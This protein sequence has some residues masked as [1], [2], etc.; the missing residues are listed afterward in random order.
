MVSRALPALLL[1]PS[2]LLVLAEDVT[3]VRT[4]VRTRSSCADTCDDVS[5]CSALRPQPGPRQEV[6]APLVGG[7][8]DLYAYGANGSEWRLWLGKGC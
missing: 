4:S 3:S 7:P 2:L 8:R 5:L 6:V 1:L